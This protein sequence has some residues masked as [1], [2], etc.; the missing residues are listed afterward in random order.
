MKLD[1]YNFLDVSAMPSDVCETCLAKHTIY[2]VRIDKDSFSLIPIDSDWL[3]NA[4]EQKSVQL[5]TLPE[6]SDMLTAST[7]EL[8]AFCRKYA[9]N[10]DAFKAIGLTF[11]RK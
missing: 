8:K 5:A 9:D 11:K 2:Q 10:L 3:K 7:K 1:T 4:L 6:D